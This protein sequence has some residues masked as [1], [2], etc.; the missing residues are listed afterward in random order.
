MTILKLDDKV[1]KNNI[2]YVKRITRVINE[3][4]QEEEGACRHLLIEILKEV[5]LE[6]EK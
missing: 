1:I 3:H 4:L 2:K 5:N 6:D